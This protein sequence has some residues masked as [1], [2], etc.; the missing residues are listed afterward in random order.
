MSEQEN[1]DVLALILE[2]L[3][4]INQSILSL[5]NKK[6]PDHDHDLIKSD[7]HDL[8]RSDLISKSCSNIE[9][10]INHCDK[11]DIDL[12]GLDLK[13]KERAIAY[14]MDNLRKITSKKAYIIT[15]LK[16]CERF[17]QQPKINNSAP[18]VPD[19]SRDILG[20]SPETV[21]S[22]TN[23]L[24]QFTY[25]RIFPTLTPAEQRMFSSF[26]KVTRSTMM[27]NILTAKCINA[28]FL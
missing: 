11:Y 3:K 15:M 5:S 7:H 25:D 23:L 2:E 9:N 14:Y 24:D 1:I 6:D 12:T 21:E 10:F 22:K 13:S 20:L 28:G 19:K 16:D 27:L 17:S 26:G 4:S 8:I 18:H